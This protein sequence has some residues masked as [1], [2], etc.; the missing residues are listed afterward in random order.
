MSFGDCQTVFPP[1]YCSIAN[2][3]FMLILPANAVSYKKIEQ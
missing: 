2:A 1:S 3:L